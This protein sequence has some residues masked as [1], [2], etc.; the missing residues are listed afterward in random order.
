MN[1]E[2]STHNVIRFSFQGEFA[3]YYTSSRWW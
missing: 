1:I 2:L 3:F